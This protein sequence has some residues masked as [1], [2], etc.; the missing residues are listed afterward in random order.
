MA[1]GIRTA[2]NGIY[3]TYTCD[4]DAA[5]VARPENFE[6]E[7]WNYYWAVTYGSPEVST[8]DPDPAAEPGEK[9]HDSMKVASATLQA[10]G[11]TVFL[12]I[13]DIKPVMQMNIKFDLLAADGASIRSEIFNSLHKLPQEQGPGK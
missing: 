6:I 5:S 13:P 1:T 11:R 8:I 2:A 10:D 9:V 12:E 7:V 4:L 3:L